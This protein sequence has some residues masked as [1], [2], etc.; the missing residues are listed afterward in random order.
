MLKYCQWKCN[1]FVNITANCSLI[2]KIT[3][4][5]KSYLI[6]N[7]DITTLPMKNVIKILTLLF[8]VML[9][10][11]GCRVLTK[12]HL[13]DN[14]FVSKHDWWYMTAWRMNHR[15]MIQCVWPLT[16]GQSTD[17]LLDLWPLML[18]FSLSFSLSVKPYRLRSSMMRSMKKTKTSTWS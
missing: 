8:L 1:M 2:S 7:S 5:L 6:S 14:L 17:P 18:C 10:T 16:S 15:K 13:A 11:T 12:T 3:L 4:L 9:Q